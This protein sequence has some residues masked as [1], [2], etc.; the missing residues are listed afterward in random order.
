[1]YNRQLAKIKNKT[2]YR[3]NRIESNRIESIKKAN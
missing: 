3:P 1:M 2:I